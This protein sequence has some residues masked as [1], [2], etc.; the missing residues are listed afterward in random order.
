MGEELDSDH[1]GATDANYRSR[2]V[3][4]TALAKKYRHGDKISTV[5]YSEEEQAV[6]KTVYQT[7]TKLYP[8]HACKEHRF[9]L[10]LL[11]TNC[12]YGGD[13]VPQLQAISEFLQDCT[14]WRLRPVT[15]L[16][17]SRD[18]LAGLAF[19]VFHSTQYIRHPAKPLYTPEP[20][21]CHEILGHVPLFADSAFAAFSQE[22]GLASLG[23]SDEDIEKLASVYW[24][25]VE[26]GL[27]KEGD[28]VRAYGAGLLS[29]FGELAYCLS[30]KPKLLPFDPAVAAVTPY[31]ITTYQP[32]YFVTESF[33]DAKKKI[34]EFA[35]TLNRPF[36]VRYNPYTQNI[37][38]LDSKEKIL[39][40]ANILKNDMSILTDALYHLSCK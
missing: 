36:S 38:V 26:F 35:K 25:T 13:S 1:P 6:W 8:T 30:D 11:E 39:T 2:R 24:F 28:Q 5:V 19:R 21:L 34:S 7:L 18:F 15:G 14:G 16:L 31:P 33:E 10:P 17:S 20:D 32:T 29:S 27:T 40:F 22:I 23:A 9:I 4:I 12:G 3:E 37:E